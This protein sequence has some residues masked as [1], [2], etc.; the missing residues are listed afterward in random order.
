MYTPITV[1]IIKNTDNKSSVAKDV[2]QLELV[3]IA[4][5][6]QNSIATLQNSLVVSYNFRD[7]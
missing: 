6:R 1:A 5:K 4:G 2:E 3:Y 7:I